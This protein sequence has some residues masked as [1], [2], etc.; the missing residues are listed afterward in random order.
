MS[1]GSSAR[2]GVSESEIATAAKKILMIDPPKT[3]E[4]NLGLQDRSGEDK[5][6]N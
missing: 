1:F 2:A 4:R 6:S 3:R 5:L